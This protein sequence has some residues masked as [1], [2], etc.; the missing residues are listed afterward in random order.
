MKIVLLPRNQKQADHLKGKS[1]EWFAR[2]RV[3]IPKAAIDGLNLL[4]HSDLVVS[5]GG[6]DE[7]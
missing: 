1:P 3:V 4:W 6:N 2:G 7:S 5:G